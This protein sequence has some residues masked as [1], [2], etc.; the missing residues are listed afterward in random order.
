MYDL[1]FLHDRDFVVENDLV[2][3]KRPTFNFK[4]R[5]FEVDNGPLRSVRYCARTKH[6]AATLMIRAKKRKTYH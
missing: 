3:T 4:N 5:I 2:K 1:I 6:N